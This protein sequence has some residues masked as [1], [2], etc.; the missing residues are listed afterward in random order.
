MLPGGRKNHTERMRK[1]ELDITKV[2]L[3]AEGKMIYL[4]VLFGPFIFMDPVSTCSINYGESSVEVSTT[5]V[6]LFFL[7]ALTVFGSG[8]LDF[9]Y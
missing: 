9:C 6:N 8:S 7:S 4:I 3:E 5:T 2:T 1:M